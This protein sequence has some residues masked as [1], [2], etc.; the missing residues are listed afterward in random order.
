MWQQIA[1]YLMNVAL[2]SDSIENLREKYMEQV[3]H[4]EISISVNPEIM[5][6]YDSIISSKCS[7]RSNIFWN[8]VC[9]S[10]LLGSISGLKFS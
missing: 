3:I 7:M 9:L 4:E 2:F 8:S 10:L 1:L 5:D 6:R